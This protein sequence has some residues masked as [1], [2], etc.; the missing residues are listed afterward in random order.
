VGSS[1]PDPRPHVPRPEDVVFPRRERVEERRKERT[2]RDVRD[3]V[4]DRATLLAVAR[5]VTQGIFQ[6]VDYSISTGKEAN[7]FRVSGL[8]GFRALKAYRI[9]NSIFRTLPPWALQELRE[10]VGGASFQR[11]IF[12]WAHREFTALKRCHEAEVPVPRPI[13]Q[14]RNL[15]VMEFIG[16]DGVADI[17]LVHSK[18]EDPAALQAELVEGTRRMVENAK[19]V[20]GDLSPFNVL[21]HDG[22][23]VII[24]VGQVIPTTHPQARAL[25]ERDASNFAR[26]FRRLGLDTTPEM[27]FRAMGGDLLQ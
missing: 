22:H 1:G 17:P 18:V 23:P 27:L 5:L 24:D 16:T 2:H 8:Q 4:F 14:L 10:S 11:L 13:A 19:L 9:N 21:V 25:L 7:V 26:Y 15:L 3:E 6:E 12:A 20:H